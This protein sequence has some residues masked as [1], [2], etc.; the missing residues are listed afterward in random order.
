MREKGIT[1]IALVIT[2]IVLLILAGVSI[3]TLTGDNGILNQAQRAKD[4]TNKSKV[5]EEIQVEVLGSYNNNGEL[6]LD[7]LNNNL[8]ENLSGVKYN[9]K[10]ISDDNKIKILPAV[11]EYDGYKLIIA[12]NEVTVAEESVEPGKEVEKTEKYNYNDGINAATIPAG[13]EVSEVSEVSDVSD[14]SDSAGAGAGAV[15]FTVFSYEYLSMFCVTVSF[16][17]LSRSR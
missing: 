8:K 12:E 14:V 15:S 6:D 7:N 13:F 5:E 11:V 3:A 9:K 4:M 10:E 16:S 17:I 2:I 1:L